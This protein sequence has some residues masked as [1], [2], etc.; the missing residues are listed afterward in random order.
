MAKLWILL[1]L[2][3]LSLHAAELN[4]AKSYNEAVKKAKIE[5]KNIMLLVTTKTCRWCRKLEATTLQDEDVVSRLNRDY[6]SVHVTRDEDEYPS[7]L[8]VKGVPTNFFLDVL[9]KPIVK[10]VVGYWNVE[11]YL[12]YLDDVD[13]KLGRKKY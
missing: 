12:F 2:G 5:K 7:D 6:V 4:W 10:K 3:F 1:C 8:E 9:G 11:D 13:Y